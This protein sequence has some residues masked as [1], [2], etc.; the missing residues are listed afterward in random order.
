MGSVTRSNFTAFKFQEISFFIGQEISG[1][2]KKVDDGTKTCNDRIKKLREEEK[3]EEL[4]EERALSNLTLGL[5]EQRNASK[6][7]A[8]A[9][10]RFEKKLDKLQSQVANLRQEL[11][12]L[13]NSSRKAV[14]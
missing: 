4:L 1:M 2:S 3:A 10:T 14:G 13:K 8:L 5:G 9:N 11:D 6:S 12:K 7:L